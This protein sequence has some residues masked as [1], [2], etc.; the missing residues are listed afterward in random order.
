[1]NKI[2]QRFRSVIQAVQSGATDSFSAYQ[3]QR[4]LRRKRALRLLSSVTEFG[5]NRF[6]DEILINLLDAGWFEER[7]WDQKQVSEF[8]A[9]FQLHYPQPA[10]DIVVEFRG[11]NIGIARSIWI[12]DID[13]S[14]RLSKGIIDILVGATLYPIGGTNIFEDDG[15]GVHV[16]TS[17]RVFVD[18]ATGYDSPQDYRIDLIASDF[19][20]LL[21]RLFSSAQVPLQASWYYSMVP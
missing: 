18:G 5:R 10:H 11:L 20:E 6:E 7:R 21:H 1:M 8:E 15:L 14:L 3:R 12:G 4:R 16:D 2:L 17:G 19:D 13:E 9:R